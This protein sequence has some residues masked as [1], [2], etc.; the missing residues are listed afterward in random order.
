MLFKCPLILFDFRKLRARVYDAFIVFM[1]TSPNNFYIKNVMENLIKEALIDVTPANDEI[2]LMVPQTNG[3]G[4]S[5]QKRRINN[6]KK[7]AKGKT[8]TANIEHEQKVCAKA[9]ECLGLL[10]VYQGALMKPVLFFV[11]QEKITSISF[12][13]TSKIQHEGDLYRDPH[14]RSFLCDIVGFMMVHPVHKMPVPLN[15][16]IALLT[17]LKNTDPDLTVRRSAE[18]NLYRAETAIH[19]KKDVFYFPA[20]YR[21]LRDTLLFNKQTIQKLTEVTSGLSQNGNNIEKANLEV[22]QDEESNDNV[23]L[24]IMTEDEGNA[25][26]DEETKEPEEVNEISD[27]EIADEAQNISDDEVIEM[28]VKSIPVADKRPAPKSKTPTVAKKTKVADK[29][30]EELLDEYLADFDDEIV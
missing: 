16:G 1:R 15:Y 2:Y 19:N 27:E 3:G 7:F 11:I 20:D 18:M 28:P 17:T 4:K 29:K 26:K 24:K 23:E 12:M 13:V 10:L 14:C 9:L 21:D 25:P 6:D 5:K 8:H 22:D 30:D